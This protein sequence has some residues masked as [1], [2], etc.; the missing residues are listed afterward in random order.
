M[1]TPFLYSKMCQKP[2]IY[3]VFRNF[4]LY[5]IFSSSQPKMVQK[6]HKTRLCI[7]DRRPKNTPEDLERVVAF[8]FFV[9]ITLFLEI[10]SRISNCF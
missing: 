4:C 10:M 6:R 9:S 5:W 3:A 8:L 7:L 1:F 2:S